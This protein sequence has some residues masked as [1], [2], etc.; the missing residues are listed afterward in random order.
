M[1]HRVDCIFRDDSRSCGEEVQG[2]NGEDEVIECV[3]AK[4]CVLHGNNS[5]Q[6]V[7]QGASRFSVI[8]Y[9]SM[10]MKRQVTLSFSLQ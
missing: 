10:L 2:N 5:R 3:P 9:S 8:A 6:D 7:K 1:E 4:N